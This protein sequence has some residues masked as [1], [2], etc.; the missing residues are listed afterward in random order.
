MVQPTTDKV[1]E[2]RRPT[3]IQTSTNHQGMS[4]SASKDAEAENTAQAVHGVGP[5]FCGV[6]Q[7]ISPMIS[8]AI[9]NPSERHN[10]TQESHQSNSQFFLEN[11][12]ISAQV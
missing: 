7:I 1:K 12:K 4:P 10:L 5:V 9:P 8:T 6:L 11:C 3:V 2:V